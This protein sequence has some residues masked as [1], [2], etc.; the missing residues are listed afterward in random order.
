MQ[1]EPHF[2]FHVGLGNHELSTRLENE[3]VTLNLG[4]LKNIYKC[5]SLI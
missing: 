4:E 2:I 5:I 3:C 1:V